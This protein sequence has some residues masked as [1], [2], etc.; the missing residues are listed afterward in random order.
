MREVDPET[1]EAGCAGRLPRWCRQQ[2]IV[3]CV[4]AGR[5]VIAGGQ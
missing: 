3:A 1:V 5:W 4:I 2:M